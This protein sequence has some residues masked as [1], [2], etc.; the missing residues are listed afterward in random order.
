MA[1]CGALVVGEPFGPVAPGVTGARLPVP[2]P[3]GHVNVWA[4]GEGDGVTL[5][6]CGVHV[7]AVTALWR[8]RL[9]PA[10]GRPVKRIIVTHLHPDHVG[11]AGWL[12]A[13]LD[14]PIWMTP[15][16]HQG[17]WALVAAA[18]SEVPDAFTAFLRAAGWEEDL[19]AQIPD[20]YGR[21]GRS[22]A[23]LPERFV[24][25]R[26]GDRLAIGGSEWRAISG[27]GHSPDHLCLLRADGAVLIGG[28]V[29]LRE[30]PA[31]VPVLFDAPEADPLAAWLD[32][33][34]RVRAA[35]G[36][37]TLILPS[38][39]L[40]FRGGPAAIDRI[41]A[42]H[43][44]KL[45]RVL[46]ALTAPM[47]VMDL[48]SRRPGETARALELRVGEMVANLNHLLEGGLIAGKRV[49]QVLYYVKA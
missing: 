26:D 27:G 18:R 47:R 10:L 41:V 23:P 22:I 2:G 24:A 16:E 1:A 25:V 44:A 36:P 33:L 15:A 5:I 31:V 21:Y 40:P 13:R 19:L 32:L 8:D 3:L 14:C 43:A 20:L 37:E 29:L 12:A 46:A 9:L 38:H 17:A 4:L 7:P 34:G 45:E 35:I 28:D 30:G 49:G 6:D 11:C 39:G 42:R 48:L